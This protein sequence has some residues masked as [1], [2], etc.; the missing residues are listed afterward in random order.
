L[1]KRFTETTKWDQDFFSNLSLKMK[2][3]WIYICDKCDHAGIWDINLKLLSFQVSEQVT[4]HEIQSSFLDKV[5]VFGNKLLIKTFVEFQYGA[6]NPSNKVHKSVL[7][8]IEKLAPTK[9]L[10][11]SIQGAK[12]K[13]KEKD[14]EKDKE[15]ETDF[16]RILNS[17]LLNHILLTKADEISI[18][19]TFL[20]NENAFGNFAPPIFQKSKSK[21]LATL[22]HVYG[23]SEFFRADLNAIINEKNTEEKIGFSKSD[24]I[25]ARLK[26]KA[27]ELHNAT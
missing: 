8:R 3:V 10:G 22:V 12:D 14:K 2:L 17:T 27:L 9:P 21:V 16:F 20:K 13:E 5:E 7:D 23:G 6:L 15:K 25:L 26:N 24:Y 4:L 18:I 11:S 19:E 1:S